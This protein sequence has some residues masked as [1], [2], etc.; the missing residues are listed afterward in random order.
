[1]KKVKNFVSI[2]A[3]SSGSIYVLEVLEDGQTTPVIIPLDTNVHM[4][5]VEIQDPSGQTTHVDLLYET[6][7]KTSDYAKGTDSVLLYRD[8]I[9]IP[10][11]TFS[12]D[13]NN[14]FK[15]DVSF[16]I[17]EN[18]RDGRM[19]QPTNMGLGNDGILI[20]RTR[21]SSGSGDTFVIIKKF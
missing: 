20:R 11:I 1:M 19:A 6:G 2:T 12:E 13:S 9:N 7:V 15:W 21:N 10:S 3:N 17:E 4:K 14:T 5:V 8:K 18:I 16:I